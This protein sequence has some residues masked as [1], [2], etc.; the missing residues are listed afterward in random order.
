V[1]LAALDN[2]AVAADLRGRWDEM[3]GWAERMLALAHA[4]GAMSHL[5]RAVHLAAAAAEGSGDLVNAIQRHERALTIFR[6]VAYRRMEA[7]TLQ[8]L[9]AS[10]LA[11]GDGHAALQW[12]VQAQA[13][14]PS[15]DLPVEA[16]ETAAYAALC[17]ARLGQPAVA[18]HRGA[19]SQRATLGDAV[20]EMATAPLRAKLAG[21][22]RPAGLQHRQVT[23]LFADMVGSTAMAQGLDA[24]DTLAV[25]GAALKRMADIVQAHQGRV[26]RFTGDGVKA[27]FGMD[28]AR[29]D[30][31]E[32]AVRAG[33]A[34]LQ[35]GRASRAGA[36]AARH[37]RP[38][39]CASA[40]TPAAWR[41]ARAWRPTTPPWARP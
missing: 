1:Q 8:R 38:S 11:Q 28:A 39:P 30:D 36:A 2:L 20:V 27:V 18:R 32:R 10:Y 25:L 12:L 3:A 23:V 29:E 24:E 21:L 22:Q 26:L 4:I 7:L 19:R 5:G 16:S 13:I 34:I 6:T 15:L 9:G 37:S 41:W 14:Y 17:Q 35:A 40:C 31:A 33:L